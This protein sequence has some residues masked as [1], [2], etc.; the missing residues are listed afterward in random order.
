MQKARCPRSP[1][2]TTTNT[3]TSTLTLTHPPRTHTRAR[4]RMACPDV[5]G[6]TSPIVRSWPAR[7]SGRALSGRS[8][9]CARAQQAPRPLDLRPHPPR[10]RP[11]LALPLRRTTARSHNGGQ[12]GRTPPGLV[13]S[14]HLAASRHPGG[15]STA[16]HHPQPVGDHPG[17]VERTMAARQVRSSTGAGG[18]LGARGCWRDRNNRPGDG[19]GTNSIVS[20]G[21]LSRDL[22]TGNKPVMM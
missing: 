18:G 12:W 16:G 15:M 6:T 11:G 19:L 9:S 8:P 20:D 14:P 10:G 4:A 21:A 17:G 2:W 13:L 7:L 3:S 1:E 5:Q 22:L